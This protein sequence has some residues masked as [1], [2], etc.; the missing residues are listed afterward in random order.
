[1]ERKVVFKIFKIIICLLL[2]IVFILGMVAVPFY[3]SITAL[4]KPETVSMVIREV[5]YK[6]IIEKNPTIEK[7]LAKYNITPEKADTI[8]KSEETGELV[9]IYAD[10]VTQIFLD[11]PEN[12]KLDITYIKELVEENTDKFLD[13]AE[14]NTNLK[15]KREKAKQNVDVFFE[16]N[17]R[18]IEESVSTIEEVRNVV[19]TIYT[20]RVV[21]K[22]ISLWIAAIIIAIGFAVIAV[23][24]CLMRSNGFLCVGINFA[25][26]SSLLCSVIGFSKTDFI[27]KLAFKISDFGSMIV[28]SAISISVGKMIIALFSSIILTMLFLSFYVALKLLKKKYQNHPFPTTSEDEVIV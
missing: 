3:Y 26:V 27:S 18:V 21:E 10:E 22:E 20:S 11:I 2:S 12:K 23:I 1:M 5:D 13:I 7:T 28:E 14:E 25:V 15:F 6:Q 24:I 17:E 19:K 4:T 8:M 16:K 9:E